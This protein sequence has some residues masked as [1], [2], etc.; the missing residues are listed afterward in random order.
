MSELLLSD[1]SIPDIFI[2][3]Y[4]AS[5]SKD[6]LCL[7]MW[8]YMTC[9]KSLRI[10]ASD[11]DS[12]GLLSKQESGLAV[13]ELISKGLLIRKSDDE[14]FLIDLKKEEVNSYIRFRF[15]DEA[16]SKFEA[17][18]KESEQRNVLASSISKTF[19][20][21]R[22]PYVLFN[23][24]D[25]CLFEYGFESQVV[26]RL[27][28]EAREKKIHLKSEEMMRMASKWNERGYKTLELLKPYFDSQKNYKEIASAMGKMSRQHLNDMDYERFDVWANELG[29][30]AQM[31][32]F[33]FR[34]NE[35]RKHIQFRHVE[36]KL[37][38]WHAANIFTLDEAMVYEN[39]RYQENKAK[40][41]QRKNKDNVWKTGADAGLT[42]DDESKKVK[43]SKSDSSSTDDSAEDDPILSLFGGSDEDN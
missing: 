42:A 39:E 32:E 14:L 15:G 28:D 31:A 4:M 5:L 17:F 12:Y 20:C 29:M 10:V 1:T 35:Y 19:Y 22:M 27:F 11:I 23:L 41:S 18:N 21:G 24:I 3:Q 36:E 16:D 13:S 9:G 6:A 34:C 37:R 7:Y 40:A 30:N 26:Y 33:A 38:E 25:R 8:L 2:V 43:E